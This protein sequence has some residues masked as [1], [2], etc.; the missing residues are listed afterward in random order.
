[1]DRSYLAVRRQLTAMKAETF[2]VGIRDSV[3]GKML[4]R[5]WNLQ[6]VLKAVPWLKQMNAAKGCDIYVRP[7]GSV[8]LV[9]I[10]DLGLGTIQRMKQE[11]V[12]PAVVVETSPL[13]FQAWVRVSAE[14]IEAKLATQIAKLLAARYGGDPNSTDWRHFGRLA[15]FTNRKP[16]YQGSQGFPFVL[17]HECKGEV[18]LEAQNLTLEARQILLA[19]DRPSDGQPASGG[20]KN[21]T[22][23]HSGSDPVAFF[24]K[25]ATNIRSEYGEATDYSRL[26]WMV[27]KQMIAQG[28][29]REDIA[30]ALQQASPALDHRKAGHVQDYTHR[31]V[32]NA[33]DAVA[34]EREQTLEK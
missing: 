25:A 6:E 8:G 21:M 26:D 4:P 33:F 24:A 31:T 11:G 17:A 9:L 34:L 7:C 2:E 3:S 16:Q 32:K 20:L 5:S 30:H 18:A 29:A 19:T 10:D 15:G 1:M 23:G 27:A 28:F 14:P 12:A 22:E 13:N